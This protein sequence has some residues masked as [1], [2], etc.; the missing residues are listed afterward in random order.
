MDD[1]LHFRLTPE[2]DERWRE[3]VLANDYT[4]TAEKPVEGCLAFYDTFDWRL[5]RKSLALYHTGDELALCQF[6][7]GQILQRLPRQSPP[8]FASDLAGGELRQRLEPVAGNRRLLPVGEA[9]T[10]TR[11]Y[12]V[13]DA[14][15]KMVARLEWMEARSGS[16]DGAPLL[17]ANLI[18]SGVR[19][20]TSHFRLLAEILFA[21][22][23]TAC[24]WE[25]LYFRVLQAAEKRPGSYSARPFFQLDPGMRADAATKIIL[26]RLLAIMRANE[27]GIKGDSDTE[28][29]HDYRTAIRRTRSALSQ[30][31]GVF[32]PQTSES[33]LETFRRL[34]EQSNRLRDLDV[35]L[36][37]ESAY[38]AMLPDD[39]RDSLAPFFAGLQ[40]Q[41]QQAW[42]EMFGYLNSAAYTHLLNE[43]EAF[44]NE[45]EVDDPLAPNGAQRIIALAR[46]R[47]Y[48]RYRQIIQEGQQLVEEAPDELLHAL[49]IDCKKLR[50]L[51]EFFASLFPQEQVDALIGQM[52]GLQNA[53]G[54]FNDLSVQR[55]YLLHAAETLPT[56]GPDSRKELVAFGYLIKRMDDDQRA[57][58]A[59]LATTF[60]E[61]AAPANRK[62]YR[63]LFKKSEH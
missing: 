53:L 37:S 35:Y 32:P 44:L 12:R 18:L 56:I 63:D 6:P 39:L 52:K 57:V 26:R 49:R 58:R 4:V 30:I 47:I 50:Y 46:Q 5:F 42:Q 45:P 1:R 10:W 15:Q 51:L 16:G 13:F 48:K 24:Q 17:D 41:R 14:I 7:D 54:A 19:G 2:Y 33:F 31:K 22:G 55:T 27:D 3:S 43:W 60:A 40:V 61:F 59:G 9:Y 21:A 8:N 23:L 20:Y 62:L 34:G 38:Q 11:Q 36:S 25:D 29:L 28:F